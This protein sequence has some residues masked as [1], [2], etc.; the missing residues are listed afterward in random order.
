MSRCQASCLPVWQR[1]SALRDTEERL[2]QA[3]ESLAYPIE[4]DLPV[5]SHRVVAPIDLDVVN[6]VGVPQV[7]LREKVAAAQSIYFSKPQRHVFPSHLLN[8]ADVDEQVCA[9]IGEHRS[10]MR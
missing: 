7:L 3:R 2:K 6:V 10:L 4:D 1:S 5:G 8:R 9:F